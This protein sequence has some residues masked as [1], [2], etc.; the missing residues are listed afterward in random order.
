MPA[1]EQRLTVTNLSH[2]EKH[3]V[4][5]MILCCCTLNGRL[6]QA[7]KISLCSQV[8]LDAALQPLCV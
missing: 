8:L 5:V 2:S 4:H 1:D 7:I 3:Q 6:L